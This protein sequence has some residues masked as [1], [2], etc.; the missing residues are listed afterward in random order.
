MATRTSYGSGFLVGAGYLMTNNHVIGTQRVAEQNVAEFGFERGRTIKRV[1][2]EP[3][4][5]FI[6]D[7]EL[8][9][10]IVACSEDA[11]GD[12]KPI[13]L[14][15]NPTTVTRND[16]VNIIQHPQGR[17]K[18]I[19]LHDNKIIRVKDKVIH[20]FTD[21]EPGSSVSPVFNNDWDLVALHHA[22]RSDDSGMATNEGIRVAAIVAHLLNRS[23]T[24]PEEIV[25][26]DILEGVTDT[27]P[28]LGFFDYYSV[29]R[30]GALEIEVADFAG[31]PDFADI[32]V[33]NLEHFNDAASDEQIDEV[34][35]VV[36]HLALDVLGLTEVEKGAMDRLVSNLG[37]RGFSM[38]YEPLRARGSQNLALLYDRD[39]TTVK[40]RRD[41][42]RRYRSA[43]RATTRSGRT[44]FPRE[45]LFAE[46]MVAE[47][48]DPAS[49]LMIVVH[50]KAFGDAQSRGRQR[51]AAEN[52]ARII[53]DIRE[54]EGLPVVLGG[55][56]SKRLDTQVLSALKAS[57]DLFAMTADD[58]TTDAVSY[59]GDSPH[60]SLIDHILV[61]KDVRI[62]EIC[63]DDAAIVRLNRSVRD[64]TQRVSDH[65]PLVFRMIYRDEPLELAPPDPEAD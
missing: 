14:L 16:R 30:P 31:S 56:F 4:R 5:F 52:L 8:D 29:G 50:L 37:S 46:C 60:R 18:E 27:S 48:R 3:N 34:A 54:R 35:D 49:F 33:W 7:K 15:R 44:A 13:P 64:F 51:L 23:E 40:L 47:D 22:G 6:T 39:T 38:D 61:S 42:N 2:L 11:V 45:P 9:F 26:D 17:E 28:Y 53:D 25:L 62:G 43:L 10:T 59:I 21:T 20:Y 36:A 32:G 41:V 57:P 24:A 65:V 63:A 1:A 19:A 55:D 58:A 12:V